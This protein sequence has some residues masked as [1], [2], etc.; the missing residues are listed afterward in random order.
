MTPATNTSYIPNFDFG[1]HELKDNADTPFYD[2]ELTSPTRFKHH[3]L[4][5]SNAI[6][7]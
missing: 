2:S 1:T 3:K 6:P 4:I 5:T 7:S